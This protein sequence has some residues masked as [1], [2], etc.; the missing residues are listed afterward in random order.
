MRAPLDAAAIH[1]GLPGRDVQVLDH[2]QSTNAD[3]M[4]IAATAAD[5][6]VVVTSDQRAGRG[7]LNRS[8][9]APPHAT[10]AMSIIIRPHNTDF[11]LLPLVAGMAVRDTLAGLG[12]QA[13]LK[14]PNDVLVDG[15]K[16]CGIL[17]EAATL[18]PPVL[19]IGIGINTD[20]T[21]AELPVAHAT[22]LR[23]LGHPSSGE[24][25]VIGVCNAFDHRLEQWQYDRGN[26]LDAFRAHCATI[27]QEVRADL[28]GD[29]AI[30]GTATDVQHTGELV[31]TDDSGRTHI[32][33]AGDVTHLRPVQ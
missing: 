23:L 1:A 5:R 18:T 13:Q 26:F 11:G 15:K 8:W 22:S 17:V 4:R 10:V 2:T 14:W 29:R 6:T 19:V 30:V 21:A 16:I 12:V 20:M 9:V 3:A 28:P 25:V 33:S 27:G 32:V 7:R 24:D 31:L